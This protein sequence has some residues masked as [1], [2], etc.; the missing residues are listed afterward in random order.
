MSLKPTN[1]P[2]RYCCDHWALNW[3]VA[4]EAIAWT[5][6]VSVRGETRELTTSS[7]VCSAAIGSSPVE[8]TT[9]SENSSGIVTEAA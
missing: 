7:V 2:S 3:D 5:M 4:A 1:T 9:S 6:A 8:L